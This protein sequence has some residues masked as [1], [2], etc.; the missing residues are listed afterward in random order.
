MKEALIIFTKNPDAGKVKTRLAATIGDEKA[1]AV[2]VRLLSHTAS[3]SSDLPMDKFV[4]YSDQIIKDDTWDDA[5]F[6]KEIQKGNDLGE[7]MENAFENIFEKGYRKIVIIGTDCPELNA[8]II[9][10]AFACLDTRDVVIGPAADGGYYLLGMPQLHGSLFRNISWSTN[11]VLKETT[12]RCHTS[13]L[14]YGLLPI[15]NDIDEEK[16]LIYFGK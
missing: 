16:D 11:I 5:V 14:K 4:F 13:N 15:L 9:I 7:K 12:D 10:N 6:Y 3:V 2:Y 1:L 8:G